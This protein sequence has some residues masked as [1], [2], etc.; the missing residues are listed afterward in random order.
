M[1]GVCQQGIVE[2]DVRDNRKLYI[3]KGN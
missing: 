3:W 2:A 1:L